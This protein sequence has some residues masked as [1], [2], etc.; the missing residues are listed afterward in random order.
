MPPPSSKKRSA[1]TRVVRRQRAERGRAGADVRDG[2][3]RAAAI[4]AALARCSNV[5]RGSVL[6]AAD[7]RRAARDTRR[8]SSTV[9]PGASP[10]QNG[11]DGRRAVR[12]LHAHAPGLDAADA[13]GRGAEQEHVAG[14][15]LD[16]EILVERADHRAFGLGDHEI[17]RV[18]RNRAAG[19]DGGQ[20][21]AAPAAHAPVH[22][23][24]MQIRAAAAARGGDALGQH[25]E[26]ASKS[27]RGSVR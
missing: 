12:V 26:T 21:R 20:T 14:Q 5:R 4:E 8:D 3:L 13:P 19:G 27:A 2:L 23:V 1:T 17:L 7:L 16:R 11:I 10:R 18:V 9:R 25:L 6:D 22:A 24:A 15:A